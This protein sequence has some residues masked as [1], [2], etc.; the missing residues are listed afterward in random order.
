MVI[1]WI[2]IF[3]LLPCLLL[4]AEFTATVSRTE[5]GK[6]EGF[7]LD[8]TLKDASATTTPSLDALKHSFII[9]FQ[10]QSS[11]TMVNNGKMMSSVTWTYFLIPQV[12]GEVRIPA[13]SI[14]TAQ[15]M[16]FTLPITMQITKEKKSSKSQ[17]EDDVQLEVETS[18]QRPYKNEPFFLTVRVTAKQ[19]VNNLQIDKFESKAPS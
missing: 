7:T 1:A 5:V 4:S 14:E 10:Q 18:K 3:L 19:S 9:K 17:E 12:Q 6:G 13:I 15:G 8:L 11:N 2:H 16:L